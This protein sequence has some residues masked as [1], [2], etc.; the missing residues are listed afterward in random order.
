MKFIVW[1]DAVYFSFYGRFHIQMFKK[2]CLR[3]KEHFNLLILGS[4]P[5]RG[6]FCSLQGCQPKI[7]VKQFFTGNPPKL[8]NNT[9]K[10]IKKISPKI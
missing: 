10:S 6:F 4:L 8:S 5:T 1:P 2:A 7:L 3:G 9:Y